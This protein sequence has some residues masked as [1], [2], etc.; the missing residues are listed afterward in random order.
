[1]RLLVT[2]HSI[3]LYEVSMT[4]TFCYT[5]ADLKRRLLSETLDEATFCCNESYF[6]ELGDAKLSP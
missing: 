5:G 4:C 3:G 6:L 1:M 2:K